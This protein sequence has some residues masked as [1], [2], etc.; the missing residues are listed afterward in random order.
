MTEVS[1]KLGNI[2]FQKITPILKLE[3]DFFPIEKVFRSFSKIQKIYM[4]WTTSDKILSK[5][6]EPFWNPST[7]TT[8]I[9]HPPPPPSVTIKKSRGQKRRPKYGVFEIKKLFSRWTI[10]EKE[11]K[12]GPHT[13]SP[14]GWS[15]HG[16]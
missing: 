12:L 1:R 9:H 13:G 14:K 8:T 6:R 15:R 4:L 7:T 5:I 2:F 10:K 11:I 16:G 3:S